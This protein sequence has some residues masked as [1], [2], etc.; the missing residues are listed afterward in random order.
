LQLFE[1]FLE[2]VLLSLEA[3]DLRVQLARLLGQLRLAQPVDLQ[4]LDSLLQNRL[5]LRIQLLLRLLRLALALYT[6]QQVAAVL[7]LAAKG[8]IAAI[9]LP[10]Y[11]ENID[12]MPD[13]Q[14]AEKSFS[15]TAHSP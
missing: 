10:N 7:V 1:A 4:R 15:K 13:I 3:Q 8:R 14:W 11:V 5:L 6:A 2:V 9:R 12:R